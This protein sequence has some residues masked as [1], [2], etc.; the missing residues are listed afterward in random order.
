[1]IDLSYLPEG[2]TG[3]QVPNKE[4]I[5]MWRSIKATTSFEHM[6]E[7]GF[8]AGHS[9]CII[10]S[11]FDDVKI[12]SYDIC[13]FPITIK[14]SMIVERKFGDR[15]SF[16]SID[17]KKLKYLKP[18]DF[19]FIDGDHTYPGVLSDFK[20]AKAS[21][22][23]YALLDDLQNPGVAEFVSKHISEYKLIQDYTYLSNTGRKV[24]ARLVQL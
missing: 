7:I 1:M 4:T 12:D 18:V 19:I 24:T 8:N 14:N 20:L 2:G 11:L 17:S 21:K 9:S 13:K 6:I 3:H 16:N 22:I 15:F 5:E 23:K 10:L